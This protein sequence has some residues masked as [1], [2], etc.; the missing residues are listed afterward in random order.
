V[1]DLVSNLATMAS[2]ES[3]PEGYPPPQAP[4]PVPPADDPPQGNPPPQ[5]PPPQY[6]PPGYPPPGYPPPPYPPYAPPGYPAYPPPGYPVTPQAPGD[7]RGVG[8]VPGAD[9]A[10]PRTTRDAWFWL[11]LAAL[12]WLAGQFLS[13]VVLFVVAIANGHTHDLSEL[14]RRA[15]PPAWVVLCGLAG[16]WVGFLGAVTLASKLRGTGRV[17]RD[18]RWGFRGWD[19][20]IG[21]GAGVV[22]QFVLLPLIYLPLQYFVPHLSDRLS[23]PAKH[24]T[25]GFHGADVAVIAVL[26]VVVV[27]VV[28]ELVFRG[29]A[30][31][32]FLR[33]FAGAG[34]ALGPA[35]A[36][37]ATGAVFGLAHGEALEFLGLM[38]FGI[39]LSVLAYKFDR[40]GPSI[41]A[42][43]SFNLVAILVVVHGASVPGAVA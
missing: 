15:V 42:H 19:P 9:E 7:R 18:M 36:V 41:F 39:V 1:F 13:A 37:V 6:P 24:L 29:L 26:T 28:E 17:L 22:G 34:R 35:L 30:L 10:P 2:G 32:G 23:Q 25:G 4:H 38:A 27:P 20:L 3:G 33:A 16:L 8:R 12:G 31:R 40:L 14:L 5:A 21:L 11:M 43:A